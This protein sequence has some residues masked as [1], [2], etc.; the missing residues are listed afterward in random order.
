MFDISLSNLQ[1]LAQLSVAINITFTALLSV[2]GNS[3]SRERL[4]VQRLLET[5]G[6]VRDQYVSRDQDSNDL[7]K[8][9]DKLITLN[10]NVD[11]SAQDIER[12]AFDLLRPCALISAFLSFC[13]L[14][15]TTLSQAKKGVFGS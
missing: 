3:F 9:I 7:R 5:A 6:Y 12:K 8:V 1:S 14:I 15:Y 10:R 11:R 4:R 2:L 13:I